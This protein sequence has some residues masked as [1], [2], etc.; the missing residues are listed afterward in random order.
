MS[1]AL[2]LLIVMLV[3]VFWF[4]PRL[5]Y[6]QQLYA[7]LKLKEHSKPAIYTEFDLSKSTWVDRLIKDSFKVFAE[8]DDFIL[9]HRFTQD[10]TNF[11]T[12]HPMLEIVV[13]VKKE[14]VMYTDPSITKYVNL[15]EADYQKKKILF[16][17]YSI[18]VVKHGLILSDEMK[19]EAD[20]IVFDKQG[21][22]HVTV[23][24]A[25]YEIKNKS[26]YF[27]YSDLFAPTAY[28]QYA[29]DLLKTLI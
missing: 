13:I 5:F 1:L 4:R 16:R 3:V 2:V 18:F 15:L 23:I 6:Y 26:L 7:F 11:I 29:V 28:Y 14:E 19:N 10:A 21:G 8:T 20:Q 24:N 27:L 9:T 22:H 25:F 17:N 12:K